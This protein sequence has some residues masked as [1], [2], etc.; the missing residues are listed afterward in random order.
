MAS[1][2]SVANVVSCINKRPWVP[3]TSLSWGRSV[4]L[5]TNHRGLRKC[6][7]LINQQLTY[8]CCWLLD[9]PWV[10][11]VINVEKH[12]TCTVFLWHYAETTSLFTADSRVRTVNGKRWFTLAKESIGPQRSLASSSCTTVCLMHST[13]KPMRCLNH[14][15]LLWWNGLE[16]LGGWPTD[17]LVSLSHEQPA[18]LT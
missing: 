3:L 1:Q 11:T 14:Y 10:D 6:D 8:F 13:L 4:T 15:L 17:A 7:R 16:I 9:L 5:V 2:W 12:A 18:V